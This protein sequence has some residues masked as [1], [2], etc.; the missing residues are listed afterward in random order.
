MISIYY[1]LIANDDRK[2]FILNTPWVIAFLKLLNWALSEDFTKCQAPWP[3]PSE[4]HTTRKSI[5]NGQGVLSLQLSVKL[6]TP[7]HG[8][9][10]TSTRDISLEAQAVVLPG[11]RV[12]AAE[13][14]LVETIWSERS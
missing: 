1:P 11:S 9:L 10:P 4:T 8:S 2:R 13:T 7:G 12:G 14:E 6:P 3:L 5:R